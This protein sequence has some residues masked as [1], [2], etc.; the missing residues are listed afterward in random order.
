MIWEYIG[1]TK[2]SRQEFPIEVNTYCNS[3]GNRIWVKNPKSLQWEIGFVSYDRKGII[4]YDNGWVFFPIVKKYPLYKRSLNEFWER[5]GFRFPF[6]F[7]LGMAI[8]LEKQVYEV[9]KGVESDYFVHRLHSSGVRSH[10]SD[11]IIT[12]HKELID[13]VFENV[14]NSYCAIEVLGTRFYHGRMRFTYHQSKNF[15]NWMTE[16]N[17]CNVLPVIS[18]IDKDNDVKFMLLNMDTLTDVFYYEYEKDHLKQRSNYSPVV[19]AEKYSFEVNDLM[20]YIGLHIKITDIIKDIEKNKPFVIY[21]NN[22]KQVFTSSGWKCKD[23][24]EY[25]KAIRGLKL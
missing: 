8:S 5:K 13:N 20:V 23:K 16:L 19:N 21:C 14:K 12:K 1:L 6:E 10:G 3:G 18:W 25:D 17:D 15:Y 7:C 22:N 4:F 24:E 9:L 2:K 11:L